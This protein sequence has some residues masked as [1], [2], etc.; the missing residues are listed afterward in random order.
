M[1]KSQESKTATLNKFEEAALENPD[2]RFGFDR[3]GALSSIGGLL[4]QARVEAHMSQQDLQQA[5]GI[6]QA[7]ISRVES[8]AMERGASLSTLVRLAHATGCRLVI[9]LTAAE[10]E[11]DRDAR[12]IT[13]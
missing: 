2:V 12:I 10:G 4:R 8:G 1:N 7:E 3:Y 9:G 6:D 13:L 11:K 5:T